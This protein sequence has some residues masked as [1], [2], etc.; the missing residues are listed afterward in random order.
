[1]GR[2][3]GIDEQQPL[4]RYASAFQRGWVE[5]GG[6]IDADDPLP[7]RNFLE[8]WQQQSQFANAEVSNEDFRQGVG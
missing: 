3:F 8:Q 7:L 2:T 1:M 4:K 5:Q 6:R